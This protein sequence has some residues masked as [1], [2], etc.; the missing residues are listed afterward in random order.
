MP[1]KL[2]HDAYSV[3]WVALLD[4][5]HE[6]LP[7]GPKDDNTYLLGLMGRHNVVIAFPGS[8]VFGTSA[9]TRT[10]TNMIR[11]FRNIRFCLM[12]G[13]GG[14]APNPP[15]P[16][17][18]LKDIRLGDVVVSSPK[19]S[20]GG[21]LQYDMGKWEDGAEF[22][23]KSHLNK[24]PNILLSAIELLKSDHDFGEGEM[25]KYIEHM[26]EKS[27][28]LPALKDY[29]FPG[30]DEDRLFKVGSFHAGG[31]DCSNCD[32]MGLEKRLERKSDEPLVHYG[33]IA[34]SNAVMRSAQRRDELRD[35]WGISCFEME[36]AGL[37]DNFPC[38]VIR[39]ICDY[40]DGHKHKF[41][42]PYAS[43]VATAYAKDLLRV[44]H[45]EEVADNETAAKIIEQVAGN[46]FAVK[47]D[48]SRI[49]LA[50]EEEQKSR[51]L[52][53]LTQVD[54]GPQQSDLFSQ[55]QRGTGQWL[56]NSDEFHKW[57][58]QPKQTLFCQGIPGA[59]KTIMT[60]II[61]DYLDTK[62]QDHG[63]GIAYIY[64]NFRQQYEQ[65]PAD[66]LA[67]LL[68]QLNWRRPSLLGCVKGLYERHRDKNTRPSF[69]E[70]SGVFIII[71]A[72]DECQISHGGRTKLLS[73]IFQLQE[74]G[75]VSLLATSRFVSEIKEEFEQKGSNFLE[76]R[77]RDEDVQIYLEEHMSLLPSFVLRN[78]N[79]QNE[80]KAAILKAVDGMF[81]LAKLHLDSLQ[82]K[83]SPTS[84]K[85][86]LRNLPKGSGAYDRAYDEA[87]GRIRGQ[88]CGFR[89]LAIR[90]LS[91]IACATRP[92]T[93]LELQHALSVEIGMSIFDKDNIPETGLMASVCA[94]LVRVDEKS[95]I[96][97]LVHY[98]LQDY[99]E[100][101]SN[102]WFAN[103]QE[104]IMKICLTYLS[105]DTFETGTCP[106]D[107]D[108][109]DRQMHFP[110]YDYAAKNWGCHA[111]ASQ[112]DSDQLVLDF[113]TKVPH[114]S[115]SI[116][117]M[118]IS[119]TYS[120]YSQ[121]FPKQVNGL[122]VSAYFGL[123]SALRF[124]LEKRYDPNAKDSHN[125]TPL[126]KLNYRDINGQ[127]LLSW[128]S[129]E[130]NEKTDLYEN[131]ALSL[132][133]LKG[134]EEVLRSLLDS[135]R[136]G[137]EC[138]LQ[139]EQKNLFVALQKGLTASV[140]QSLECGA[141]PNKMDADK[142]T[143]LELAMQGGHIAVVELLLEKG[144]NPNTKDKHGLTP[145]SWAAS[146]GHI[147]VVELL[148][149][150]GANPES[151]D[152]G[153]RTPLS[154]AASC[155]HIAVVEL[156]LKGAYP[157]SK[158]TIYSRTLLL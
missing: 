29:R 84:I 103:A 155:G 117:A 31:D 39:G 124:L 73:E 25:M 14:G 32:V 128:A 56:L 76:I 22:T 145:L 26:A 115:A 44:I 109:E 153:G 92:L 69:E 68:K 129:N 125:R 75:E 111:K 33:L 100:R 110:L 81:L 4:E 77:A 38:L 1:R 141:D 28:K 85:I 9:A 36:A 154:R 71:D 134:H 42:Q 53:W 78:P 27:T 58:D 19:G 5:E 72:L 80:L 157:D 3:G 104:D 94:G 13:V 46:L 97:R 86:A 120:G 152:K 2:S 88:M 41:W 79:I 30:R 118:E 91:W 132:A 23:I 142:R 66:L 93:T 108:F 55:Q 95:N 50:V 11:T 147:A 122:H 82:D 43:V 105:F 62:Y 123:D 135:N 45:P 130:G 21:V 8:G 52:S 150:K 87:M 65:T 67:S 47:E 102:E 106:S 40:S 74:R 116:Q 138:K 112:R 119:E 35:A 149:K 121:L 24:P 136:I 60:S 113:L 156:L 107:K 140:K 99:F 83:I 64:C 51:I 146:R 49:N 6:R 34:S 15:D 7:P 139:Y 90:V 158:D 59:G 143:P 114:L 101:T 151:N 131:T 63:I 61:I 133:Q 96:I 16:E 89:N 144:A 98:T 54:Y 18:P 17:D 12:V 57:L 37:M 148:L 20:H 127:T 126:V 70:I 137:L 48:V 10:A